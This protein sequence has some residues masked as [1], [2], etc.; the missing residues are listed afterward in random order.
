[1]VRTGRPNHACPIM[2]PNCA[3]QCSQAAELP[4][5]GGGGAK[6]YCM[7]YIGMYGPNGYGFSAVLVINLVSILP[8]FC[9][10]AA[11]ILVLNRVSIWAVWS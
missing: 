3:V 5:G 9:Y 11:M 10:F 6:L 2:Q 7:G 8:R 4:V 1:M